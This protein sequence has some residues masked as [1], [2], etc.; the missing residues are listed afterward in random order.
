MFVKPNFCAS[1]PKKGR[2]KLTHQIAG[3]KNSCI[4]KVIYL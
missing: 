3:L 2:K 4:M 1:V